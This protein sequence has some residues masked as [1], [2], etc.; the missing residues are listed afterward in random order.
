MV[1]R[2]LM[3]QILQDLLSIQKLLKDLLHIQG[4]RFLSQTLIHQ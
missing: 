2:I 4:H 1:Q 3:W